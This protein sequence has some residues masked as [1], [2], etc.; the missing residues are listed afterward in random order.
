MADPSQ[1]KLY[2]RDRLRYLRDEL[3]YL[4]R[5]TDSLKKAAQPTKCQSPKNPPHQNHRNSPSESQLAQLQLRTHHVRTHSTQSTAAT[6]TNATNTTNVNVSTHVQSQPIQPMLP[7]NASNATNAFICQYQP[8]QPNTQS[9]HNNSHLV[10]QHNIQTQ[11]NH[12]LP[13]SIHHQPHQMKSQP[14]HPQY[15]H[16]TP[17]ITSQC[18]HCITT[19]SIQ[20]QYNPQFTRSH[21]TQ[22]FNIQCVQTQPDEKQSENANQ[23]E[24]SRAITPFS[25]KFRTDSQLHRISFIFER[26]MA[27]VSRET[28][29]DCSTAFSESVK[30]FFRRYNPPAPR[31]V[32]LK[33]EMIQ[34]IQS[35]VNQIQSDEKNANARV[36]VFGSE[37]LKIRTKHSDI[38]IGIRLPF[39]TNTRTKRMF[40]KQFMCA[41]N[42]EQVT[43]KSLVRAKYPIIQIY[44]ADKMQFDVSVAD[45]YC[46][47]TKKIITELFD[48]F[49]RIH[50]PVRPLVVFVKYWAKQRG[51]LNAFK[52]FLNSF[53]YTILTV[54]YLQFVTHHGL[55]VLER[56]KRYNDTLWYLIHGFFCFYVNFD[57]TK[58]SIQI[59]RNVSRYQIYDKMDHSLFEIIDPANA[60]NNIA[61]NVGRNEYQ[62]IHSEFCRSYGICSAFSK[63]VADIRKSYASLFN[64]LI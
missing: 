49:E 20:T 45:E 5:L 61:S 14:V 32:E 55:L 33:N 8:M 43:I 60:R 36:F 46:L 59:M 56:G 28:H 17:C 41:I 24:Q 9:N 23:F 21:Q 18:T 63:N 22:S 29:I 34:M 44:N 12:I 40:L 47:K 15:S 11:P 3:L 30:S 62:R 57:L 51:I 42:K 52:R 64:Q 4:Q 13:R 35:H 27:R 54:N 48:E 6:A 10:L 16:I 26:Y 25:S 53:G 50:V 7:A 31:E 39:R 1:Y 37:S 19:P 38:D 58:Q 2:V